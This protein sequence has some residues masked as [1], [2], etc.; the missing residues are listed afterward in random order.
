MLPAS[1][2]LVA[3]SNR[4]KL[5][6][7]QA[8]LANLQIVFLTPYDLG[9]EIEVD[10]TGHTYMENASLKARAYCHLAKTPTLADDSGLEVDALGGAPGIRSARYAPQPGAT[11]ADRRQYLLEQLHPFPRPWNARFR[12][13]IA[14]AEASGVLHFFM[15]ICEG[16]IIPEERG[17]GGFG[18]DPIFLVEGKGQT[19]AELSFSEKNQI[20]HRARALHAAYPTLVEVLSRSFTQ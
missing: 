4:G 3:T 1:K 18:Y 2:V 7:F 8:L 5:R 13:A 6:E 20:S 10:E 17:E 14:L 19:M 11:D 15:G 9:I 16:Q 12:C